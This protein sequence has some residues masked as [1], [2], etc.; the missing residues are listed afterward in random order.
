MHGRGTTC[1][2]QEEGK[3][4]INSLV[5]ESKGKSPLWRPMKRTEDNMEIDLKETGCEMWTG[6]KFS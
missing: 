6:F 5:E 1:N 3:K 4:C 2:T